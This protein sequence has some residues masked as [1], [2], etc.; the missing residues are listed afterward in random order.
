MSPL[1]EIMAALE[2][3]K[4]LVHELP[5]VEDVVIPVSPERYRELLAKGLIGPDGRLVS[6]RFMTYVL[7]GA[8][9][10]NSEG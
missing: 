9:L 7:P 5:V 6:E 3:H 8:N 10:P 2:R 1:E 4:N